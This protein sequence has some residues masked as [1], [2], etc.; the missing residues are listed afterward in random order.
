[1]ASGFEQV[2]IGQARPMPGSPQVMRRLAEKY[3]IIYL[4]HRPDYFG[5]KSKAWLRANDYPAGPLLL[6]NI[7]GFLGG[8][9]RFKTRAIGRLRERFANILIGIGDKVSDARAY[10]DN[11]M[12]AFLILDIPESPTPGQ[13]RETAAA[14]ASLGPRVQVVTSWSQIERAVFAGG[15]YPPSEARR[16]L[17]QRAKALQAK[18]RPSRASGQAPP[19]GR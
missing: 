11:G 9:G 7:G 15:S 4:T 13:L 12:R 5:P 1:V 2:L 17:E 19:T 14:L 3:A 18:E 10:D 16:M 8:S 6:S